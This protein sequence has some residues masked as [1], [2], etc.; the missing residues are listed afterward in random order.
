[1]RFILNC[2]KIYKSLWGASFI[3]YLF[4]IN[5]TFYSFILFDQKGTLEEYRY[6]SYKY[7]KKLQLDYYLYENI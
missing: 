2:M 6:Y 4:I 1:M 5:N 7:V 3:Q